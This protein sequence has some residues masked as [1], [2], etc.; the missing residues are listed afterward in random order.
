M[1]FGKI[2]AGLFGLL[3]AGLPGLVVGVLVGHF[4][5]RAL[6][7]SAGLHSPA[8]LQRIRESFFETTFVL[9]GYLAKADGR[10]SE[11]EVAHTER[12]FVELGLS[13]QQ[14]QRAIEQFRRGAAPDF[15]PQAVV[16]KFLETCGRK[17]RL[18]QTLLAF[19]I[20]L[21]LADQRLESAEHDALARIAELLGMGAAQLDLLLRMARAQEQFHGAADERTG[22]T[23][24]GLADAYA[25]LGVDSGASDRELKRAYR[26]RMSEHHPD[27]LIARG[28]PEEMVKLGTERAQ[29]IQ[30]AYDLIRRE[31]GIGK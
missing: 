26:K 9:S 17:P 15:E 3:A 19:L 6:Q 7:S 10:V 25:A 22:R 13:P 27:K 24:A 28:V 16:A 12:V 30:A 29:E 11:D 4:F 18:R 5:D 20:S 1:F 8:A 23:G 31:R 21:A 14:R 2:I